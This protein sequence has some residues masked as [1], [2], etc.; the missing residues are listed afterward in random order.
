MFFRIGMIYF[1]YRYKLLES[2]NFPIITWENLLALI[3][4]IIGTTMWFVYLGRDEVFTA[5]FT[6]WSF[7]L[8][9]FIC[10]TFLFT[11]P[12]SARNQFVRRFYGIFVGK[13]MC[14]FTA[15]EKWITGVNRKGYL[16]H[17]TAANMLKHNL[18]KEDDLNKSDSF[19]IVRNPYSRLVSIYMYNRMGPLESFDHFIRDWINNKM[20]IYRETGSTSEWDIYCHALPGFEFTHLDGKQ[21]VKSIIKQEEL[22]KLFKPGSL[23]S[24]R[25]INRLRE[26]PEKVAEALQGMPHSNQR[27]RSK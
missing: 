8:F 20:K 9:S 18:V 15:S 4:L 7:A 13:I 5:S 6:M 24:T 14:N 25:H 21:I 26:I 3:E 11:A 10:S 2:A 1:F 22:G 12:V 17:F 23:Q 16:V 27:K 19:A